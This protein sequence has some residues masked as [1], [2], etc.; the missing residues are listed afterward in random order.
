MA[1]E[2]CSDGDENTGSGNI[3]HPFLKLSEYATRCKCNYF[4]AFHAPSDTQTFNDVLIFSN[5][6]PG[7]SDKYND[8]FPAI[9]TELSSLAASTITP[10]NWTFE[11]IDPQETADTGKHL[12]D[13][14]RDFRLLDG[15]IIPVHGPGANLGIVVLGGLQRTLNSVEI[16]ILQSISIEM[17]DH[18]HA[19][20][21]QNQIEKLQLNENDVVILQQLVDGKTVDEISEILALSPLS[22]AVFI[23]NT[24]SKLNA[25]TNVEAAARALKEG[26][27]G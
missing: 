23:S 22:I 2:T 3:G 26:I 25:S 20:N 1:T 8:F 16:S 11:T 5:W 7:L 27:V 24:R 14:I 18:H 15:L 21:R 4:A 17:F 9:H 10:F 6:P 12:E 19:E 13:I